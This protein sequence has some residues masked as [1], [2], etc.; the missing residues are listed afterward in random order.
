MEPR[1][2]ETCA[3]R[4]P[5]CLSRPAANAASETRSGPMALI[6]KTFR[7]RSKFKL[8]S[9]M[10]S[11]VPGYAGPASC[12]VATPDAVT[13]TSI[14]TSRSLSAF[15]KASVLAWSVTSRPNSTCTFFS[16]PAAATAA[17]TCALLDRHAA[18]TS[19]PAAANRTANAAP[20]PPFAPVMRIVSAAAVAASAA[21]AATKS[22]LLWCI[23]HEQAS[24]LLL[25]FSPRAR[26]VWSKKE[27]ALRDV[28][29]SACR[30]SRAQLALCVAA[31]HG[32]PP[33]VRAAE[34]FARGRRSPSRPLRPRERATGVGCLKQ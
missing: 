12:H 3:T 15:T 6:S 18:K 20:M 11:V 8:P 28:D 30:P 24:P 25:A 19:F 32:C 27:A 17:W 26:D 7:I 21:A 10:G 13:R 14:T 29:R 2:D 1:R 5:G 31:P 22:K 9:V 4:P 23:R 16:R 33:R 34:A